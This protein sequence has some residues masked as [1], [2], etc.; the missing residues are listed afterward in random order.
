VLLD[1]IGRGT[2]TWDGLSIAWAVSEHL[3]ERVECKTVFATHY[4]ELTQLADELSAV[5]NF[6]VAVQEVGEKILFLHRLRPGGADRSYGI[7]VGRLAG[8]PAP[9]IA[10]A[11]ALLR[12]LESEQLVPALG[13]APTTANTE[14]TE[15]SASRRQRRAGPDSMR[16]GGAVP[17]QLGLFARPT[18]HPVVERLRTLDPDSLTPRQALEILAELRDASQE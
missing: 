17:D 11:R 16:N 12:V 10:R 15:D 14:H 6:N 2:A 5:R 8:L 3:H 1:E 9:V 13:T 18:P 4:H 7:E